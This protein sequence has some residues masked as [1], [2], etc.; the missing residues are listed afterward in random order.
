MSYRRTR[1]L[2]G[3]TT[4]RAVGVEVSPHLFRTSAAST[5]AIY[6]GENPNLASAVLHHTDSSITEAHYNRA[7]SL[8]AAKSF[9]RIV[10]AYDNEV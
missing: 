4:L 2:I 8:S 9:R 10:R 5:A 6:G 3:D 1:G 7:T